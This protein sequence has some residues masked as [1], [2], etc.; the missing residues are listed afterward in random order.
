[1]VGSS[2]R[3]Y[4]HDPKQSVSFAE[5]L[6]QVNVLNRLENNHRFLYSYSLFTPT[7]LLCLSSAVSLV[8]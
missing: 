3:V 7:R 5:C 6:H 8:N 1:M 4:T 2:V